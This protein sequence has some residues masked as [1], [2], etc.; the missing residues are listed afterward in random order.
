MENSVQTNASPERDLVEHPIVDSYFKEV[1]N[2][3]V[4]CPCD[5]YEVCDYDAN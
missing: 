4:A 1:L 5:D 2:D 3:S